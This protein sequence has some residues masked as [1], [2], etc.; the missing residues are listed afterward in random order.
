MLL[1][2]S[3]AATTAAHDENLVLG[4][5][6]GRV[7]ARWELGEHGQVTASTTLYHPVLQIVGSMPFSRPEKA[8]PEAP[9]GV[10]EAA[11]DIAPLPVAVDFVNIFDGELRW[12]R[13]GRR[14]QPLR[15]HGMAMSIE[16]F[17][18]DRARSDGLP[19]L[20]TGRGR[21][22]RKGRCAL[23]VT[24][25][26]WTDRLDFAGRVQIAGLQLE[27]L[28]G[29]VQRRTEVR[30]TSGTLA[31]FV[32]FTVHDGQLAGGIRPILT[33]ADVAAANSS[34]S[35]DVETWGVDAALDLFSRDV[36]GGERV[37]ATIPLEGR[38][39]DPQLPLWT[40]LWTVIDN[41]FFEAVDAGFE[42]LRPG[43][44]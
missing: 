2:T 4:L 11:R 32:Q 10:G 41:A 36:P 28:S 25:N 29:L 26:P 31:V 23:F 24:M 39:Q 1:S 30:P 14:E 42:S 15:V 18:T 3:A 8:R 20:I 34:L 7:A 43:A 12:I 9:P 44:Q 22:G 6:H 40:A 21:I 37:A 33:N 16:N 17:S 19:M 38:L 27:E 35:S 13:S 5:D